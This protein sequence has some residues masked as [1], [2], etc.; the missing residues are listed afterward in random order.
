MVMAP[1]AERG[2]AAVLASGH[3]ACERVRSVGV[4][5][6]DGDSDCRGSERVVGSGRS[7]IVRRAHDASGREVAR[8]LFRCHGLVKAIHYA[9]FGAPSPYVWCEDALCAAILR[10][11]ILAALVEYWFGD[12]LRVAR[13]LAYRHDPRRSTYELDTEWI[14]GRHAALR[15]PWSSASRNELHELR[16]GLLRPL[17]LRLAEAGFDGQ[18]W[19]AGLGNPVALNN[20]MLGRRQTGEEGWFWIDLESGVPALFPL[21]PMALVRFYL[22]KAVHHGGALFDDVDIPRLRRYLARE[23]AGLVATLGPDRARGTR[24]L[25]EA[26]ASCE[27]R[28]RSLPRWR[29]RRIAAAARRPGF[30]RFA[31]SP[32]GLVER[33]IRAVQRIAA[34]ARKLRSVALGHPADAVRSYVER[35]IEHWRGRHQLGPADAATLRAGL[36]D[37]NLRLTSRFLMYDTLTRLGSSVP[38]WG[39]SDTLTEHAM[40]HLAD[41]LVRTLDRGRA[42]MSG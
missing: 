13:A 42:Q 16:R 6:H 36:V 3:L 26:L 14:E 31:L 1:Q 39:G 34:H 28:W 30:V 37:R 10:R 5:G 11:D 22:P 15:H 8:K 17:Q 18:L 23:E 27:G 38:I 20:F 24:Q 29:R 9:V 25:V 32:R 2:R 19:Q 4:G 7:G 41:A 35:R 33:T 12:R 40:N 21:D